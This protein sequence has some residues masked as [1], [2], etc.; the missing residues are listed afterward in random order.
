MEGFFVNLS[1]KEILAMNLKYYRFLLQLTQAEFAYKATIDLKY[2][3]ELENAHKKPSI[4]MLDK[5][6]LQINKL[7]GKNI[8][9]SN[10]LI[11]YY[12]DHKVDKWR[13]DKK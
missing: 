13:V 12:P 2:Y 7:A 9:S 11:T 8:V 10:E 5:L 6:A 1:S 4:E 3:V